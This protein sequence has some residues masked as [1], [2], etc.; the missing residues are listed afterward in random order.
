MSP[1]A[2]SL[3]GSTRHGPIVE[4]CRATSRRPAPRERRAW[5]A[6]MSAKSVMGHSADGTAASYPVAARSISAQCPGGA[7]SPR[8]PADENGSSDR[9]TAG[10][11]PSA[12][13]FRTSTLRAGGPPPLGRGHSFVLDRAAAR[14]MGVASASVQGS[15]R[16]PLRCPRSRGRRRADFVRQK[17]FRRHRRTPAPRRRP[18]RANQGGGTCGAGKGK[19]GHR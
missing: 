17:A 11:G 6:W 2:A 5:A 10:S 3:G 8:W 13:R 4:A 7:I 19:A 9:R 14:A 18:G 15:H 12:L 1:W 16:T